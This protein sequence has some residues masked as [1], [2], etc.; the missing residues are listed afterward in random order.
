MIIIPAR[1]ASTRFPQKILYPIDGIPMVVRTALQAAKVD[2]VVIATDDKKVVEVVKQYGFE[3]VLTS[4][5]H[6]S[7]TDRVNEAAAILGLDEHETIINVQGDEPYIE[8]EV[9]RSV[10]ELTNSFKNESQI[11]LCS[12]YKKVYR[13]E[14][15]PNS[16]KVVLNA[17]S[18]ALYFS[19]SLIPYPRE[20]IESVNIHLGIY[21][22]TRAKL[23]RFCS[24]VQAP[25]EKIEKLEQLRAL[26]HG[27]SIAMTEVQSQSIGIDTPQDLEKLKNAFVQ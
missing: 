22:Y 2:N 9:I 19:R 25:L 1:L 11:L 7:G 6:E 15:D 17:S 16:V 13:L 20:E 12:A 24:L 23:K 5:Q 3:A 26:Y 4:K 10:Y 21:G 27:Y 8:P 18:H 14:E